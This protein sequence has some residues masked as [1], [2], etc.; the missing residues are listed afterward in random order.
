MRE[1]CTT[2]LN[3]VEDHAR[4][5]EID[6][7]AAVLRCLFSLHMQLRHNQHLLLGKL[8]EHITETGGISFL[9]TRCGS[10]LIARL[11]DGMKCSRLVGQPSSRG[12]SSTHWQEQR[13]YM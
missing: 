9:D 12:Q 4:S 1:D 6:K 8:L 11:Y 5:Y 3:G 2:E 13:S 10:F 7:V